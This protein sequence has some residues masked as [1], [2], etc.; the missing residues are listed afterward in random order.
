MKTTR[1]PV[2]VLLAL[3]LAGCS[4]P[5]ARI[6]KNPELFAGFPPD[7]QA[8]V[9]A[10]KIEIGYNKDMVYIALGKPDREYT[11]RTAT[12]QFEVWSYVGT[13][14]TI[15]RQLVSGPF[16]V[17]DPQRGYRTVYDSVWVDVQQLHEYERLRVEFEDGTVQAVEHL[18]RGP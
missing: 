3:L 8:N 6:K 5:D 16:R 1:C 14:S 7:V 2:P 12:G 18:D 9:K 10:G 11:R 15:D 13:F 17:R 4:T